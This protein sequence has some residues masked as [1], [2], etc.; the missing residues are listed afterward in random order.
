VAAT[1]AGKPA[2][3]SSAEVAD[4]TG[5]QRQLPFIGSRGG[6][7][8]SPP[9]DRPLG[10]IQQTQQA[11]SP[12]FFRWTRD[13]GELPRPITTTAVIGIAIAFRPSSDHPR[14]ERANFLAC[15]TMMSS[16]S[17]AVRTFL[18]S[19]GMIRPCERTLSQVARVRSPPQAGDTST[20]LLRTV[21]ARGD[22]Q[23]AGRV[24]L[25][26]TTVLE[27]RRRSLR[28]GRMMRCAHAGASISIQPASSRVQG[29]QKSEVRFSYFR[30]AGVSG[31]Y[32]PEDGGAARATGP[33]IS[34]RMPAFAHSC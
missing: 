29:R 34:E 5:V 16:N 24:D 1:T 21:L 12:F 3:A 28:S 15:F 10:V 20:R 13:P 30:K 6:S 33:A 7:Q 17:L 14:S 4:S 11:C 23:R 27:V 31:R 25:Q 26:R 18:G 9:H 19:L 32:E 8:Q 2:S 22:E